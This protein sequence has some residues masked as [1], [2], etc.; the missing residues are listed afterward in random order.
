M[1]HRPQRVVGLAAAMLVAAALVVAGSGPAD[2]IATAVPLGTAGS[3]GVLAGSAVTNTGPSVITGDVGVSPG[4]SIT[5]F[6]PGGISG[7]FHAADAPA[8][9]AKTDL[10]TAYNDAAGQATDGALPRTPAG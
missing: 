6:P 3:Y 2:A 5:G 4:S 8:A 10:V 7:V 1:T 9:Q